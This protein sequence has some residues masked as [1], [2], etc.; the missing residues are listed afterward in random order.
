MIPGVADGATAKGDYRG[1]GRGRHDTFCGIPPDK[2]G[3]TQTPGKRWWGKE[4]IYNRG[5]PEQATAGARGD[6]T[7]GRGKLVETT[8]TQVGY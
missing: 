6:H 3:G 2:K 4:K 8:M 5:T 7:G 1:G